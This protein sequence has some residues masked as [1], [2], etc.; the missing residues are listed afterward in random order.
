MTGFGSKGEGGVKN[1]SLIFVLGNLMDGCEIQS[2]KGR[3]GGGEE[4]EIE[5]NF[6]HCEFE[7]PVGNL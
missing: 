7:V 1:D 6:R 2:L 3:A 5:S 4:K